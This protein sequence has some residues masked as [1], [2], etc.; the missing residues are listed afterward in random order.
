MV[1]ELRG[2][3]TNEYLKFL[4]EVKMI[5]PSDYHFSDTWIKHRYVGNPIINHDGSIAE[6][7]IKRQDKDGRI[8]LDL[9]NKHFDVEHKFFSL[10]DVIVDERQLDYTDTEPLDLATPGNVIGKLLR[11][12]EVKEVVKYYVQNGGFVAVK[13]NR[14]KKIFVAETPSDIE[15]PEELQR[16][17]ERFKEAVSNVFYENKNSRLYERYEKRI[18]TA[19]N[20]ALITYIFEYAFHP[21]WAYE[22]LNFV[23]NINNGSLYELPGRALEFIPTKEFGAIVAVGLG[24]YLTPGI[25]RDF[26][27]SGINKRIK[28]RTDILEILLD[29]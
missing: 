26:K 9:V 11:D 10:V 2:W 3:K 12:T 16:T 27:R 4:D 25:I 19:L 24:F 21:E 8:Y 22:L 28:G 6:E 15:L 13:G 29:E 20:V 17:E 5:P 1:M 7:Y 18:E 14:R 23:G